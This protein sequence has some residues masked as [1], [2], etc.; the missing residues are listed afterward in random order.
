MKWMKILQLKS[1]HS[2]RAL[3]LIKKNG[4]ASK[5]IEFGVIFIDKLVSAFKSET[6]STKLFLLTFY[7]KTCR[8][9]TGRQFL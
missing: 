5:E 3:I 7:H 2:S 1:V 6:R 8:M 9:N 4:L